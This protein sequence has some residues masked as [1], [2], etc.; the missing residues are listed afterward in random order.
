MMQ[1]ILSKDNNYHIGNF[2]LPSGEFTK[3]DQEVADH[4]LETHLPG[5]E[6]S[7]V[8]ISL[9][10]DSVG[11]PTEENWIEASRIISEDKIRWAIAGFGPFKT[12][13]EGGIFSALLKNGIE[14]LI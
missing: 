4:L 11:P 10:P 13:G 14:V 12:A 7:S 3:S 9:S 8:E 1:K 6:P 2:R 5:C